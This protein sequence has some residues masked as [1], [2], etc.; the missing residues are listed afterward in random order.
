MCLQNL[1][2]FWNDDV[3]VELVIAWIY[4]GYYWLDAFLNFRKWATFEHFEQNLNL[5]DKAS[6]PSII[7]LFVCDWYEEANFLS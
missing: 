2:W 3:D 5:L 1:V 7:N 4:F 6:A